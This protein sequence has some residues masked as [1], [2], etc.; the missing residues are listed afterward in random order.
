MRCENGDH[1]WCPLQNNGGAVHGS[2][3]S[4]VTIEHSTLPNNTAVVSILGMMRG[5]V[6]QFADGD[7]AWCCLQSQ[8]GAVC[9]FGT[10]TSFELFLI[11]VDILLLKNPYYQTLNNCPYPSIFLL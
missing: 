4:T 9:G 8:G 1:A 11:L 10:V 7:H 5:S 6:M 3:S 2:S